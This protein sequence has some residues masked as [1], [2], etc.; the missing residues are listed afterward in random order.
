M[1][2]NIIDKNKTVEGELSNFILVGYYFDEPKDL[3]RLF[4]SDGD[5]QYFAHYHFSELD[6]KD[7]AINFNHIN[8][9]NI[10]HLSYIDQFHIDVPDDEQVMHGAADISRGK[11]WSFNQY[12]VPMLDLETLHVYSLIYDAGDQLQAFDKDVLRK[13]GNGWYVDADG[14]IVEKENIDIRLIDPERINYNHVSE[15]HGR[16]GIFN[17]SDHFVKYDV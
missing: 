14:N 13:C 9:S 15:L 1:L 10:S 7:N 8:W 16:W 2:F 5:V 6:V 12:F 3:I 17:G 11:Q 4:T